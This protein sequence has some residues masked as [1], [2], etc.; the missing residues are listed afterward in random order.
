MGGVG[1]E[2]EPTSGNGGR[3]GTYLTSG[4]EGTYSTNGVG[5]KGGWKRTSVVTGN[6]ARVALGE[7]A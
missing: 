4:S 1:T 2:V 5:G 3:G 6:G 7:G